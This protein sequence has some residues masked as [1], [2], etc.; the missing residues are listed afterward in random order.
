VIYST[1]NNLVAC[2]PFKQRHVE[3]VVKGGFAMV[4]KKVQL[5]ELQVVYPAMLPGEVQVLPGDSVWVR[6]DQVIQPWAKDVFDIETEKPFILVP[7]N[8]VLVLK[9]K[10]Y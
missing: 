1:Q 10:S 5:E 9:N 6:A 2:T 7:S 8:Y 3:K 4:D